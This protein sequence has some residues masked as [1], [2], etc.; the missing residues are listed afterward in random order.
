M[1]RD[2]HR[3]QLTDIISF[4]VVDDLGGSYVDVGL[5]DGCGPAVA[6]CRFSTSNQRAGC[7]VRRLQLYRV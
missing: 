7:L 2:Y 5:M 3:R 6:G 1:A 4:I